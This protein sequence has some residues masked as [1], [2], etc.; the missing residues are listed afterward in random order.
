MRDRN[1]LYLFLGLN[2]ALA[3]A[4]VA[5]LVVSNNS[6]PKVI[7]TGFPDVSRSNKTHAAAATTNIVKPAAAKTN[8]S[9]VVVAPPSNSLPAQAEIQESTANSAPLQQPVLT[10]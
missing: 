6:Q 3:G 2:V 10:Q 9:A 7:A 1:L 5:Y 8:T 4:F